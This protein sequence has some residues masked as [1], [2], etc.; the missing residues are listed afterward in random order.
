MEVPVGRVTEIERAGLAA[1]SVGE[2]TRYIEAVG[3]RLEIT[4]DFGGDRIVLR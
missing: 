4:T 1:A 3:G 2:L